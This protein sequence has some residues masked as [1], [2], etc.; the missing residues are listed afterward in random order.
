[1]KNGKLREQSI[2]MTLSI[3]FGSF[4]RL[5]QNAFAGHITITGREVEA[6][7][8]I[9]CDSLRFSWHRRQISQR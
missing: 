4:I 1:M 3:F 5:A 2:E 7:A 8:A 9:L 6:M